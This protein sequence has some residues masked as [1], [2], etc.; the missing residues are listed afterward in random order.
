M[1]VLPILNNEKSDTDSATGDR[2]QTGNAEWQKQL[3]TAIREPALLLDLLD[4]TGKVRDYA[5]D[6]PFSLLVPLSFVQRMVPGDPQDPL[7]RQ[8][9]PTL[10]ES[11]FVGGFSADPVGDSLAETSPG[12]LQKY[13]GRTLLIAAGSCAVNC[14]YCFRREYPYA[15]APRSL[16]DWGAALA[17]LSGDSRVDEIILSGGD[18]LTL[19]DNRLRTLLELIARQPGISR[20]RIHSRMP[21]VL[22]ARVTQQLLDLLGE[23]RFQTIM[24]VHANHGNEIAND[25]AEALQR[26]VRSGIPVLN[27]AVLLRSIN[28]TAD[29]QEL[30]CRRLINL[31][32]IP[33][34][35]H[36]LDR[37]SGAAHFESA[38]TEGQAIIRELRNRLP[39]YAVPRYVR[40][41]SGRSSKTPIPESDPM[42]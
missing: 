22:P 38:E 3:A 26:L 16:E 5:E 41:I 9:L 12:V 35:L 15:D 11:Q 27:Q 23:F 7:L 37:V 13:A 34:Y 17:G 21:I 10:A 24:V 19:N 32:V 20:V 30:L 14:R 6:S 36:Q 33:Y 1:S 42:S 29:A 28:D 39:G 4:L 25:C 31:G 8:V 40:E 18:P 2:A